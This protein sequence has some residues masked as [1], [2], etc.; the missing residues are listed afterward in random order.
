MHRCSR[1]SR[2]LRD[3]SDRYA[4][5][6]QLPCALYLVASEVPPRATE[7]FA[8]RSS[9]L[10]PRDG[11]LAQSPAFL[12][13]DPREDGEQEITRR[14]GRVEP[15]FAHA[16]HLDAD[17]VELDDRR[18]VA[19]HGSADTI[20]R[21]D[22][23]HAKASGASVGEH[24]I[25]RWTRMRERARRLDVVAHETDIATPRHTLDVGSLVFRIHAP[26]GH[27][28]IG[29]RLNA[30]SLAGRPDPRPARE[31][32]LAGRF[33]RRTEVFFHGASP[34]PPVETGPAGVLGRCA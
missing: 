30:L 10:E 19:H 22:D 8:A 24:P 6:P 3:H 25:E 13:G 28:A 2:T 33:R 32:A 12:L 23:E 29:G 9:A 20:E 17:A 21:P 7:S 1:H 18:E 15:R 31:N 34:D 5:L 14:P 16:D 27:P 4:V 26:L 11:S